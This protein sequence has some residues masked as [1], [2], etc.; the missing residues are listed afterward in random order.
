MMQVLANFAA[1]GVRMQQQQK[2]LIDQAR[3]AGEAAM[4]H[5]LAHQINN[6]LQGLAQIVYLLGK[7]RPE[8]NVF[9]KQAMEEL[10]RLSDLV[11]QQLSN[12]GAGLLG[13]STQFENGAQESE[14]RRC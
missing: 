2:L 10:M 6:P 3:A 1:T 14:G 7:E 5:S 8:P 12:R 13:I 9:A 11:K 4:A